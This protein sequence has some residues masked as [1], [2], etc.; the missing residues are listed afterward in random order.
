AGALAVGVEGALGAPVALAALAV[1]RRGPVAAV[2]GAWSA[3]LLGLAAVV[4]AYPWL[5]PR[6]LPVVLEVLGIGGGWPAALAVVAGA[7]LLAGGWS[8]AARL[9]PVRQGGPPPPAAGVPGDSERAPA[10]MA[11]AALGLLVVL[12]V[13]SGGTDAVGGAGRVLDA[14]GPAWTLAARDLGSTGPVEKLVLDS[15]LAN[16]VGLPEGTPVATVRLRGRDGREQVWTLRMGRETGEWAAGRPGPDGASAP[17]PWIAWVAEE[18]TFFGRR[19]RAV[20]H[21]PAAVV[22]E[23]LELTRRSDLPPE[24]ALTVFHLELR[25]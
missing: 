14:K 21:L 9:R 23:A 8:L 2:Q 24:V 7:A 17:R 12:G 25:P 19:Y 11:L 20:R 4:A 18:G 15:T 1:P 13:P 16:A 6:P 22:P 10:A 3:T 5:R